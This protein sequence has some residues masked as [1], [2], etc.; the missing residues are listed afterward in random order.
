MAPQLR[1]P[2]FSIHGFYIAFSCS[3]LSG[4]ISIFDNK[5][6]VAVGISDDLTSKYNAVDL[7]KIASQVLG[8]KGGGGRKDFAQAGGVDKEKIEKVF[9]ELSKNIN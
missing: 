2:S 3:I 8:G 5:L 1:D 4:A 6:A 9:T 7:V